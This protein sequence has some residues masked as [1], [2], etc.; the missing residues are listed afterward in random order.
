MW[1]PIF[2]PDHPNEKLYLYINIFTFLLFLEKNDIFGPALDFHQ[3]KCM[4]LLTP[5]NVLRAT[6][7]V[8]L[9]KSHYGSF[10]KCVAPFFTRCDLYCKGQ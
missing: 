8:F 1:G 5:G 3:G 4:H 6:R 9:N 7:I 10:R 2:L